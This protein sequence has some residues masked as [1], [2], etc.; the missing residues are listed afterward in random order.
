MPMLR[1][2][3]DDQLKHIKNMINVAGGDI[4][5]KLKGDIAAKY[6][7]DTLDH[8]IDL[9]DDEPSTKTDKQLKNLPKNSLITKFGNFNSKRK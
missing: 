8:T 5:K 7:K 1:K 9:S 6:T 4:S 2:H 3:T